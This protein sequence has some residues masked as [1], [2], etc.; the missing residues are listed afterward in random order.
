MTIGGRVDSKNE[1]SKFNAVK[2]ITLKTPIITAADDK[3]CN[4][5]PNFSKKKYDVS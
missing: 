2:D 5:F 3:F 4:L 1:A